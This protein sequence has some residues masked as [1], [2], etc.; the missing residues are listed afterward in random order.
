MNKLEEI[1][2]FQQKIEIIKNEIKSFALNGDE[3][4]E[5]FHFS[6]AFCLTIESLEKSVAYLNAAI[7]LFKD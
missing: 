6:H 5:H 1:K 3:V 4:T 2:L 7:S